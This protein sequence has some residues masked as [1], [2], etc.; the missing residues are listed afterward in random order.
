[1][2]GLFRWTRLLGRLNI[3][4]KINFIQAFNVVTSFQ[5][6]CCCITKGQLWMSTRQVFFLFQANPPRQPGTAVQVINYVKTCSRPIMA[7]RE[8]VNLIRWIIHR[9][10][11]A[12]VPQTIYASARDTEK[13]VRT[14]LF[15]LFEKA[16]KKRLLSLIHLLRMSQR[17]RLA[18]RVRNR[19]WAV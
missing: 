19:K 18:C 13:I 12:N 8:V 5:R 6:P 3:Y 11:P 14:F 10:L 17:R 1:M 15:P 7:R 9:S 4:L 2:I 16:A